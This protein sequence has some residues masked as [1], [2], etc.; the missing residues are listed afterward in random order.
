MT[1]AA[2]LPF[3]IRTNVS[4]VVYVSS[5]I[6]D[7]ARRPPGPVHACCEQKQGAPQ[8]P[9]CAVRQQHRDNQDKPDNTLVN[10]VKMMRVPQQRMPSHACSNRETKNDRFAY[11]H[12]QAL[13]A[14]AN[15]RHS[16]VQLETAAAAWSKI[17][18]SG[19]VKFRCTRQV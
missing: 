18:H 16:L 4:C 15:A 10:D 13:R 5:V 6:R 2:V 9:C 14:I 3:R 11:A 1:G 17:L 12:T 19:K 8:L 7:R